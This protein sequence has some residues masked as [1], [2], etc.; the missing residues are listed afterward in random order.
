MKTAVLACV[1]LGLVHAQNPLARP[2][3][4]VGTFQ[5]DQVTLE[6]MGA[7]GQYS[8][9]LTVQ[10]HKLPVTAKSG[11][12]N[13]TGSFEVN[14]R[15]YSFT[16]TPVGS[17]LKLAS[18]GAEYTLVRKGATTVSP[19]D[20]EGDQPRS[21]SIVGSWRSATG[22]ARFN[23]DGTGVVDGQPGRY[24][25]SGNQLTLIGAQGQ[26]TLP[27]EVRQ[28]SLTLTVNGVAVV[29]N[30]VREETG[31]GSIHAELVGKWCWSSMVNA[32]QGGRQSNQCI[33]ME[34]NGA[35]TYVGGSDNYNP[36]GGA[37]TQS[38]D[39]GTWTATETTLTAHSRSGKTTVYALEKRNHP[40]NKDPMIVLNGQ[41][42]VTY[43]NK[44]PW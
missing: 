17:G 27:F 15:T 40:K 42:F 37:T 4:F 43:Y 21:G 2:D 5:G 16:L 39:S 24:E 38:A 35:Y 36:Y 6:M 29:L 11:T 20:P 22:S 41:T 18:E 1:L 30:R 7:R 34:P 10:G 14:G 32:Q 19:A 9:S 13:A 26:V 25:I 23:A 44:P 3:P 28:D 8:G 31:S 33:T 12:G